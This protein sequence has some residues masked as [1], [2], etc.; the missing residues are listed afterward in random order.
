MQHNCES[1]ILLPFAFCLLPFAF[2]LLPFAFCLLPFNFQLSTFNFQLSSSAILSLSVALF[3]SDL[4]DALKR[5]AN[6]EFDSVEQRDGLLAQVTSSTDLKARDVIWMLF[7]P[8][9]A[10]RDA[11]A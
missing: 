6:K 2:C 9:R 8:D 11:G 10:I 3:Q 4:K 5:L 7:R 1:G